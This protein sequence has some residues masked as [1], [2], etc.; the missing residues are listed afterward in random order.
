MDPPTRVVAADPARIAVRGGDSAVKRRGQFQCYERQAPSD[1]LR[2]RRDQPA[3]FPFEHS[4]ANSNTGP[5]QLAEPAACHERI[6]I[7][8]A[9]DNF[10]DTGAN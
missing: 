1:V 2:E 8:Y 7:F 3:A 5:P 6:G 10:L 4:Y 9:T